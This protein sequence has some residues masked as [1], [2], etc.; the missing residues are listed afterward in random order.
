MHPER[1]L[2][3]V[4][5]GSNLGDSGSLLRLAMDRLETLSAAPLVRSSLWRSTPVDCP[6]GSADFVNAVV[7]LVP[8]EGQTSDSLLE[9]LQAIE[10]EFGRRPKQ[11]VNE[12]R[13]LDLDLVA[14]EGEVRH[15]AR[16]VLPHP[17]A[18]LRRFVL[19]PLCEVAPDLLLPGQ[20]VAIAELLAE[21]APG[22]VVERLDKTGVG[23]LQRTVG[24]GEVPCPAK[25]PAGD[26]E[27]KARG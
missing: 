13:P 7:L 3:V 14:F 22:E 17:R 6:P 16:L 21:L 23:V 18:H 26:S 5:L 20:K 8:R 25:R 10:R 24:R 27:V 4:A 12:P 11:V 2:A 9:S 15:S 19:A 1:R